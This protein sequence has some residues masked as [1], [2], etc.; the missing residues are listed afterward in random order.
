M[1]RTAA[2]VAGMQVPR[3]ATIVSATVVPGGQDDDVEV[4]TV[5]ADGEVKRTPASEYSPKGRGTKGVQA[6]PDRLAFCGVATDLHLPTD[7]PTV[8]R[9]VEVPEARRTGRGADLDTT[10]GGPGVPEL[11]ADAW[12]APWTDR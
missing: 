4:V 6:G 5:G 3:D 8:V 9:L 10:V 2:G 11:D 12:R 1:G 7:P